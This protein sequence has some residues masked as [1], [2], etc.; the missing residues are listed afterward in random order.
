VIAKPK[1][2]LIV[3]AA[4]SALATGG[5]VWMAIKA[6]GEWRGWAWAALAS[7]LALRCLVI[8]VVGI[9]A[10][11]LVLA[12]LISL[13]RFTRP[14]PAGRLHGDQGGTAAIEM[15]FVFPLALMIF[16]TVTQAAL[17]FNAN[18]VVHYATFCAAR[19]GSVVVPLDMWNDGTWPERANWVRN[20]NVSQVPKSEKLQLIRRAAVMALMPISA[21]AKS[22]ASGTG[23]SGGTAIQNESSQVFRHFGVK[24]QR[25]WFFLLSSK[26][27][28]EPWFK[29]AKA[30]YDYAN[31]DITIQ[32]SP[33]QVT[34][35]ELGGEVNDVDNLAAEI[36][37]EPWH[38][39]HDRDKNCP[40][41]DGAKEWDATGMW[42]NYQFCP[43]KHDEGVDDARLDFEQWE[44]LFVGVTYQYLLEVPYANRFLGDE[45]SV[46]GVNGKSYVARIRAVVPLS[47]EGGTEVPAK[48]QQQP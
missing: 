24:D 32:G 29:R 16:L 12:V 43:T 45:A 38:W 26:P 44:Y 7:P 8:M 39:R 42:K 23:D 9:L 25:P 27:S 21:V 11:G 40:Y 3:L 15:A 31:G 22:G 30:K 5:V 28:Y 35:I 34:K 10:L 47:N 37:Q 46:P 36:V 41:P 1:R 19:V 48:D 18:M 20:P 6:S 14:A 33:T 4:A 17:L 13:R 2:G